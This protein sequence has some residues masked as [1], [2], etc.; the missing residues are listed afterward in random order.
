M[1]PVGIGGCNP[2]T[3]MDLSDST[4]LRNMQG[5]VINGFGPCGLHGLCAAGIPD[6]E[7][8]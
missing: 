7:K 1:S 5:N 3:R 8:N 2:S 6:I 4:T